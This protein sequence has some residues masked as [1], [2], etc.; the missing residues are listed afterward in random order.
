MVGVAVLSWEEVVCLEA[1]SLV[2]V[3]VCLG[4]FSLVVV[5]AA[6]LGAFSLVEVAAYLGVFSLVEVAAS[7]ETLQAAQY[8]R[9]D[10]PF[11][12]LSRKSDASDKRDF[13]FRTYEN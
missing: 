6:Y 3:A 11:S 10:S 12:D 8:S 2:V 13:L 9:W 5:A 4:A 7:F 1:F